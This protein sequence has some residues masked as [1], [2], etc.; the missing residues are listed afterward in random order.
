MVPLNMA[1][2]KGLV[3]VQSLMPSLTRIDRAG[4]SIDH[5]SHRSREDVVFAAFT[6]DEL[7]GIYGPN[8]REVVGPKNSEF[9]DMYV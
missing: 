7:D 4:I 1:I 9:I 5:Y 6:V 2:T 8:G 3:P